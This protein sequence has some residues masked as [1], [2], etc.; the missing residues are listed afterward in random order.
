MK[1]VVTKGDQNIINQVFTCPFCKCQWSSDEYYNRRL[2]ITTTD[3]GKPIVL[4]RFK[5]RDECPEC[6]LDVEKTISEDEA[7][8]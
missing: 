7:Y 5:L 6:G 1:I 8:D 3:A 4:T 2:S